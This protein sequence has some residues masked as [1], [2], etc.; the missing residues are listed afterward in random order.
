MTYDKYISN[1]SEWLIKQ[2]RHPSFD[3]IT[4]YMYFLYL[5]RLFLL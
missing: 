3:R 1:L 2:N 4:Q 5:E